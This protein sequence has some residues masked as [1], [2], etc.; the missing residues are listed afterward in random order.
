MRKIRKRTKAFLVLS[1]LITIFFSV[2]SSAEKWI[3][4][5][6]TGTNGLEFQGNYGDLKGQKSVSGYIPETYN[7]LGEGI[8][9]AVFQKME[10]DGYLKVSIEVDGKE[11]NSQYTTAPY[12]VVSLTAD[13]FKLKMQ[14][15]YSE[16]KDGGIG[17]Y[18]IGLLIALGVGI[19]VYTDAKKRGKT[20]GSAFVWFLGVFFLLIIFLPAWL[21]TRPKL[22]EEVKTTEQHQPKLCPHCGKYYEGSPSF[23]PNCG[24]SLREKNEQSL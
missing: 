24:Q 13:L 9:S 23:C 1:I 4:I 15:S 14:K 5:K 3:N 17:M 2:V 21:I 12:G 8:V 6:I 11:L 20:S 7:F 19:W 10:E 18:I 22:P 16:N